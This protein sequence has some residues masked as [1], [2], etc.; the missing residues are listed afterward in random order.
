MEILPPDDS[1]IQQAINA[2]RTGQVIAYPT[3]SV[4]G[5][6]VD[7]FNPDALEALYKTKGRDA[8]NPVLMI[9]SSQDQLMRLVETI[10][11]AAQSA[12]DAFWPG[13]LSLLFTAKKGL[14]ERLLGG[15]QKICVRHTN[16][17]IAA[18]LCTAFDGPIIS[19]SAN[20][21]SQNPAQSA[22]EIN[23]PDVALCI[24]GGVAN[25]TP[26]TVFDPDTGTVLREGAITRIDIA[27]SLF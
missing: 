2:L 18:A 27:N 26:S 7:P 5:L 11:P 19:T 14:P 10:T 6:G 15:H 12:M 21:Y 20:L 22:Q 17:P 4:Y 24:D 8:S 23:L 1:G 13:P 3:E 25:S 9:I 16:H